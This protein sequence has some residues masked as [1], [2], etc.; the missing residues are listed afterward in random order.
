MISS[1]ASVGGDSDDSEERRMNEHRFKIRE[2]VT[3]AVQARQAA[4]A[5]RRSRDRGQHNEQ[6]DTI[7][8]LQRDLE[9]QRERHAQGMLEMKRSQDEIYRELQEREGGWKEGASHSG[10]EGSPAPKAA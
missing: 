7:P 10:R 3:R 9:D 6:E 8:Q 4:E 2:D 1:G 5:E